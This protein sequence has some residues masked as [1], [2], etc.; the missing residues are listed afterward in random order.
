MIRNRKVNFLLIVITTIIGLA[1]RKYPV[2][3]GYFLAEYL[4]DTL[5]A[6]LIYWIFGWIFK[7]VLYALF[8][9]YFIEISQLY[10][11][12]WIDGIRSTRLGALLLGHGFLWTDI[13]CYTVGIFL[14]AT[15]E[16]YLQ[17]RSETG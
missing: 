11:A 10:H 1:S 17:K 6:L 9:S 4:G 7:I 5:W 16:Y 13:V 3:F 14:G 15:G 2:F 12:T 8:F